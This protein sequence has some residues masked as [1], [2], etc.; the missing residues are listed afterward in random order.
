MWMWL[1]GNNEE[2]R[3]YYED[4]EPLDQNCHTHSHACYV[5]SLFGCVAFC[6]QTSQMS[7]S[8]I[9]SGAL[10]RMATKE[11]SSGAD[12]YMIQAE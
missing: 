4:I 9:Q 5:G 8:H 10:S 7:M 2:L 12:I 3:G 11:W 1:L 6:G